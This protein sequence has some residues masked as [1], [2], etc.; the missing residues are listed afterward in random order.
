MPSTRRMAPIRGG[1]LVKR[2]PGRTGNERYGEGGG[3]G[4][5]RA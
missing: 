3:G 1:G 4:R 2:Y 5:G